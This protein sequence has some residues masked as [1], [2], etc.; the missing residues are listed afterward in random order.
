[1]TNTPALRPLC[2]IA[3]DIKKAWR[4]EGVFTRSPRPGFVYYSTPYI[5]ALLTMQSAETD[6]GADSGISVVLY[7]LSNLSGWRGP[8]AKRLKAELKAHTAKH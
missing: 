4:E 6:Y 8:N 3:V 5:D 2:D 1:M 7:A